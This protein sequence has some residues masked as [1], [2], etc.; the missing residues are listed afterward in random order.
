MLSRSTSTRANSESS[1]SVVRDTVVYGLCVSAHA[2]V[3][4]GSG[5]RVG[6]VNISELAKAEAGVACCSLIIEA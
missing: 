1:K 5:I 6:A 3:A 4:E 2:G